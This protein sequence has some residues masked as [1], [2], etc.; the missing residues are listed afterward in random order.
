MYG[1]KYYVVFTRD[2][3]LLQIYEPCLIFP[4]N[5]QGA[6]VIAP[7]IIQYYGCAEIRIGETIVSIINCFYIQ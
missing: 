1:L 4:N 7:V 5:F 6:F 2:A 3:I